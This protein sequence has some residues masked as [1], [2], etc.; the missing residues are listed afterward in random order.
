MEKLLVVEDEKETA[1]IISKFLKRKGFDV[2]VAYDLKSGMNRF[3]PYYK[4]VLLDILLNGEKSF[5]LLKKIKEESPETI[6]I[7]VSAY[8]LDQNIAEAKKLGADAFIAKPIMNEY[9]E[10]FLLSKIHSLRRKGT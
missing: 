8:D 6:V 4:V 5:P 3:L 10:N 2:D 9:L 1:D 7:V